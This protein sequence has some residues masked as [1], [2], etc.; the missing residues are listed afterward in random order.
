MSERFD[1]TGSVSVVTGGA[2]LVGHAISEALAAHGS[3]VV[4]VDPDADRGQEVAA[5]LG[6]RGRHVA[7]DV[8]DPAAV[9]AVFETVADDYDRLDVLVNSAYPRNERYGRRYEDVTTQDFRENVTSNLDACFLPTR[10][11]VD[12]MSATGGG[13]VINIG[14]IYGVQAPDFG[15]YEGTDMT[16][17]VE[18]AVIKGGIVNLTRY[19]ASYLGP[20]GIR[21]NAIS[22]GGVHDGQDPRFVERYEERTPIGRMAHPE[23]FGGAA[24]FLAAPASAYVT[25]HNLVVDGGFTIC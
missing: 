21:V 15:V 16:S 2:G 25:G 10:H 13:S 8:T 24:V 20:D 23:D 12:L 18:Y 19:L 1:L 6:E 7:A 14:S 17:P 22:P 4:V 9:E 11:A 3:T 5:D